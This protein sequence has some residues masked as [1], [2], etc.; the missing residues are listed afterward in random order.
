MAAEQCFGSLGPELTLDQVAAATGLTR[1]TLYGYAATRE[2]L[3]VLLTER[4]LD[5]WFN[6]VTPALRRAKTS[7][8]VARAICAHIVDQPRLPPLLALCG[9]VFERN[10]SLDAATRWKQHLHDQVLATGSVIDE[11]TGSTQG[12]G[13]RLLLHVHAT[14]TGLYS[15]AT[16]PPVAAKAIVDAGLGALQIDFAT[17]LR[18][19]IT[20]LSS[21][22]LQPSRPPKT[23]KKDPR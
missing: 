3:L 10:I 1:T 20:A 21:T 12:S 7:T 5:R 22:I 2:E 11:A 17:E 9:S 6:V 18:L 4:E 13:A 16:P 15:V 14:V 23:T 19:A 8:G